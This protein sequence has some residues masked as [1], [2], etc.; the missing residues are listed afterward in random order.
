MLHREHGKNLVETMKL[1]QKMNVTPIDTVA[2]DKLRVKGAG[3][4]AALVPLEDSHFGSAY[5]A[6]MIKG[7]AEVLDMIDNRLLKSADSDAL[8]KHLTQ[9]RDHVAMHLEEAKKVQASLK[10]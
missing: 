6:A 7:H 10:R 1:G 2:V 4:L 8:K 9:T 5:M 3:E